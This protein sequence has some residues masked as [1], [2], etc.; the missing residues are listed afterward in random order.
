MSTSLEDDRYCFAC[1]PDN[2]SGLR[3]ESN[4][5]EGTAE[6]RWT[7]GREYQGFKGILHGGIVSTLLD[8]AMAHAVLSVVSGAATAALSVRFQ[9]PVSTDRDVTI[10]ARVEER[11]GRVLLA[12]GVLTQEGREMATAEGK[13]VLLRGPRAV[14]SE[15]G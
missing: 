11:R 1:G 2:P 8:E 13:F 12:K 4:R 6:I 9:R 14:E 7:P 10:R 3:V 5:E 15:T